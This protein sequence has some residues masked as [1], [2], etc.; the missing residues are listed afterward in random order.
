[1]SKAYRLSFRSDDAL[2]RKG[3]VFVPGD[4][5]PVRVGQTPECDVRLTQHP[6]LADTCY[7]VLLAEGEEVRLIR[8]DQDADIFLNGLP[9]AMAATLRDGDKLC[10]DRTEVLFSLSSESAPPAPVYINAKHTSPLLSGGLIVLALAVVGIVG[11]LAGQRISI[12]RAF[13]EEMAS[14]YSVRTDSLI[15][16]RGG[17]RVA[18]LAVRPAFVGSGFVTDDGYFVTARH[19]LEYWLTEEALLQADTCAIHSS[20]VL[21]AI[22]AELDTS[23]VLRSVI[24]VLDASGQLVET[25]SSTDFT[26]D[27]SRDNLYDLGNEDIAYL[28]RSLIS[29]YSDQEAELGDVAV[30]RWH[31]APGKI[32]RSDMLPTA[33]S[34]LILFGYPTAELSPERPLSF[35]RTAMMV[36]DSDKRFRTEKEVD[37]GYSGGP[38]FY[39]SGGK[40]TVVGLIS[41]SSGNHTLLIS[42]P[43]VDK[44]IKSMQP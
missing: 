41:R 22:R 13:R 10:F 38:A 27:K 32:H 43:E 9:L 15:V 33:D 35:L 18:A 44:L 3:D 26:M 20:S 24:S 21:W 5:A 8:Q 39:R 34:E 4:G 16:E 29:H 6:E 11:Y 14:I 7:A 1:M 17:V 37:Q 23:L 30:V 19:C 25:L 2:H 40:K 12:Q 31:G 36:S 42:M 28:W